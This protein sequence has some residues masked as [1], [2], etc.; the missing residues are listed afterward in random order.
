MFILSL[1][2]VVFENPLYDTGCVMRNGACKDGIAKINGNIILWQYNENVR[3]EQ[4]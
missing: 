3:M 2:A 1:N 4:M